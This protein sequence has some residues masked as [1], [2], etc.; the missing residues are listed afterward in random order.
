MSVAGRR[1]EPW[2]ELGQG[3]DVRARHARVEDIPDDRDGQALDFLF[4]L[5]D[6]KRSEKPL[7]RMFMVPVSGIDDV[8]AQARAKSSGAPDTEWRSTM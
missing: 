6:R 1:G 3:P 7:R 5:A 2:R 4:L 8:R